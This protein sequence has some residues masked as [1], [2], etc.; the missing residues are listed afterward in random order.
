VPGGVKIAFVLLAK[1][2]KTVHWVAKC[3]L[4]L[5]MQKKKILKAFSHFSC[6]VPVFL[7]G[8]ETKKFG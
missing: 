6:L 2:K 7:S 5:S 3:F 8:K 1:R 4:V